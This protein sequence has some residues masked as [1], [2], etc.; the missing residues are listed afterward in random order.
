MKLTER[1]IKTLTCPPGKKDRLVGDS[2]QRGLYVRISAA[3][4]RVY[5]AQYTFAGKKRRVP[6][7]SC[8]AL[9][10]A[11]A[12]TACASIMADRALGFD[13]AAERK[14]EAAAA[15]AQAASDRF[16][17]GALID[18]WQTLHL[19]TRR[20]RHAAEAVRALRRAF[21]KQ[22]NLPAETLDRRVVVLAL[23]ALQKAG[24]QSMAS[25]T[26]AYGRAC[27]RWGQRR[28][29]ITANPF[30]ELPAIGMRPSRDRVLDDDE[31]VRIWRAAET[32]YGF[33]KIV[34][35]LILTGA[36][37]SEVSGMEWSELDAKRSTWTIPQHRTGTKN[38]PTHIV[39]LSEP[40]RAIICGCPQ[41]ARLVFPGERPGKPLNGWSKSK[42]RLDE[43]SGVTVWRLHDLRR[44]IATGMQRLGVRLEV[45]E[46]VLNHVGTRA[47]IVGIYQRHDFAAEKAAALA[48]WAQHVTEVVTRTAQIGAVKCQYKQ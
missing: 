26:A 47:G 2:D 34:Q 16:T 18:N 41:L 10:L 30:S 35:L 23:D 40:A 5:L 20:P 32:M 24:H 6:I 22:W 39:P 37:R 25:R 46:A 17:V 15:R 3:G 28:G 13:P 21:A 12:R 44:S 1:S 14:G 42:A 8:K 7:G 19:G 45:T 27:F 43:A 31:L 9:T 48:L 33:G 29:M 4:G 36:R 38:R 11:A